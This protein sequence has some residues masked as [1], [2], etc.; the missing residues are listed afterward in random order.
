[1]RKELGELALFFARDGR[2][3]HE[4]GF[5]GQSQN[6]IHHLAHALRL[7]RQVVVRAVRATSAGIQQAQVVVNF[8]DRTDGGARVMA[9]GFLLNRNS[10]RQAFDEVDIGLVH[11]VQELSR[12]GRQALHIPT[13]ALG[14]QGVKRQTRFTRPT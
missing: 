1:M 2:Q 11:H 12:V 14:I 13:L 10:G 9:S 6:G 8:S 3:D 5:F 7:Q 4:L